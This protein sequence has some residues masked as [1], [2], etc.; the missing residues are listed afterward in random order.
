MSE[1]SSTMMMPSL[2]SPK[3]PT[4]SNMKRNAFIQQ[5]GATPLTRSKGGVVSGRTPKMQAKQGRVEEKR[6]STVKEAGRKEEKRLN[7]SMAS[8]CSERRE[9]RDSEI[10]GQISSLFSAI[11]T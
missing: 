2:K 11:K 7:S 10:I 6:R 4:G 8:G 3:S 5:S 9:E 1:L